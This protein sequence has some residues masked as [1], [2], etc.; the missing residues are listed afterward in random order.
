MIELVG[1]FEPATIRHHG[2]LGSLSSE[3]TSPPR[4][5]SPWKAVKY[6]MVDSCGWLEHF[7]GDAGAFL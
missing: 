4:P 3:L 6:I 2:R 5:E 1:I 7:T